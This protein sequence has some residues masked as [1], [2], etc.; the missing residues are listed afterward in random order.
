MGFP[1]E[2]ETAIRN[3]AASP[4][5][6]RIIQFSFLGNCVNYKSSS[7]MNYFTAGGE[8]LRYYVSALSIKRS[9]CDE[10]L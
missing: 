1:D 9:R 10:L 6:W 8:R 2:V 5:H 4:R 7:G 3:K